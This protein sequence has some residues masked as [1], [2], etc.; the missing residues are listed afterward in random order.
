MGAIASAVVFAA[1]DIGFEVV[2]AGVFD[3]DHVQ[4]VGRTAGVIDDDKGLADTQTTN[5]TTGDQ[6]TGAGCVGGEVV[7][8]VQQGVGFVFKPIGSGTIIVLQIGL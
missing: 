4:V 7:F 1:A 5:G 8:G 3:G 2:D 6:L